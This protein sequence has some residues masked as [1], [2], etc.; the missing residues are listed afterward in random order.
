MCP[1]PSA[2]C[3]IIVMAEDL[4]GRPP[5]L[6][7]QGEA[8]APGRCLSIATGLPS[9]QVVVGHGTMVGTGRNRP[10]TQ[11]GTMGL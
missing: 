2:E 1:R 9:V 8:P 5:V 7:G 6:I 10:G 11:R 4:I 3:P